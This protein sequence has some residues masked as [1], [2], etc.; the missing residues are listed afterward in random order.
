MNLEIRDHLEDLV[1]NRKI[2]F[3]RAARKWLAQV[4]GSFRHDDEISVT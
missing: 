1:L 4:E 3:K 2:I